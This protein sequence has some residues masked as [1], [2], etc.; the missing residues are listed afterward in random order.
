MTRPEPPPAEVPGPPY[1]CSCCGHRVFAD[2]PGS[3]YICPVCSWEDDLLQVRWPLFDGGANKLTLVQA[4][5][6]YA[7]FGASQDRRRERVRPPEPG[8]EP[9]EAWRPIDLAVDDFE[10]TLEAERPWPT[11]RTVLYWWSD[12][13]WRR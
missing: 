6:N 1:P 12:R 8:R 11:D 13:F 7:A 4:Q 2:P 9:P 10:E 5:E 3:S